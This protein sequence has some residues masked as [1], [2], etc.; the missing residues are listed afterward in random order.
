MA[1]QQLQ[2]AHA[3]LA[4]AQNPLWRV[5]DATVAALRR[6]YTRLVREN[7]ALRARHQRA[8][9]DTRAWQPRDVLVIIALIIALLKDFLDL[10]IV[11]ALPGV[12]AVFAMLFAVLIVVVFLLH[13][14]GAKHRRVRK[15]VTRSGIVMITGLIEGIFFGLNIFPLETVVVLLTYWH[16]RVSRRRRRQDLLRDLHRQNKHHA[17]ALRMLRRVR[18]AA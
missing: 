1:A 11:L 15:M 14:S 5:Q 9:H 12:G 2:K 3:A 7:A 17:R 13:A 8:M 16:I 18:N 10:T 6:R 4:A